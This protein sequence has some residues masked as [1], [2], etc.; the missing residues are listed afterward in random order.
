MIA[1]ALFPSWEVSAAAQDTVDF[2][3]SPPEWQTAICL[4][5]DSQKSLVDK[6]GE[7]LYH[8][9]GGPGR[10]FGT[11]IAVEVVSNAVWQT[12]TLYSPRV[13]IVQ[14]HRAADGLQIVEEAFA[15]TDPMPGG[16]SEQQAGPPRNDLI[17]VRITN[18]GAV[19][20]SLSPRLIVDT[21]LDYRRLGETGVVV[22]GHE[23]I[24][25]SLK[26]TGPVEENKSRRAIQLE[27]LAVAPGKSAEF[28]VLY[29]GGGTIVL[30]PSTLEQAVAAREHAVAYWKKRRCRG[31]G[32]RFPMPG[33]R[34]CWIPPS[35]TSGRRAKSRMG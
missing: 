2:R 34:R 19:A 8:Y 23:T 24:S 20:R 6:S 7:L 4:P 26:M 18:T 30:S 29:S 14:T 31:G 21:T 35:A 16:P 17:L 10:E 28:F 27:S 12:Q 25:A 9:K 22:N 13:P 5:D 3:Y 15:V 11:R 32:S 1:A 33:F